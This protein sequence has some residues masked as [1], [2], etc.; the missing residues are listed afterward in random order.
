MRFFLNG[1]QV[2]HLNSQ[3]NLEFLTSQLSG[4]SVRALMITGT[5][6]N[7]NVNINFLTHLGNASTIAEIRAIFGN[8]HDNKI[9]GP[10]PIDF[11]ILKRLFNIFPA[12]FS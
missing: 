11:H 12:I 7:D 5:S 10:D 3:S 6:L 2:A 1:I 8:F 9:P 4:E